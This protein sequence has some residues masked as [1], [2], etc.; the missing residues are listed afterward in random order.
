MTTTR[1]LRGPVRL[2]PAR[3]DGRGRGRGRL[4][5]DGPV[6]RPPDPRRRRRRR[7]R[8]RPAAGAARGAA[9]GARGGGDPGA[10]RLGLWVAERYC[11]TPSRGLAL[12]LPPGSGYRRASAKP[13]RPLTERSAGSPTRGGPR[14]RPGR[15]PAARLPPAGGSRALAAEGELPGPADPRAGRRR[16][17][18]PR[19]A[20]RARPDR[21]SGPR[22]PAGA[23]DRDRRRRLAAPP[24]LSPRQAAC[25]DE[26]IAALDG[27][28]PRERLLHGVTGSGQDRGLP[29]GD[30]G[31]ARARPDRDPARPRDRADA[32]DRR[33]GRR[34]ARRSGGGAPL[35]ALGGRALR[36]V[37]PAPLG[38]RAGLRRTALGG[39]RTARRPRAH[40]RRRGA[41]LLLQA[42]GRSR[43]TT[44]AP[45]PAAAPPTPER[46]TWPA[47][48]PRG[49]RAGPSSS[50][51]SSPSGSTAGRC[52]RSRSSTCARFPGGA[53]PLHPRT[54]EALATLGEGGRG[55]EGDRDAEPPRLL[56]AP[57]LRLLRRGGH[58][59]ELR[60]LAR[61]PPRPRRSS[62]ATTAA[63]PSRCRR[64]AGSAAR[65]RSPATAPGPSGSSS[66][67]ASSSRRRRVFRLDADT[68]SVAGRPRERARPSSSGPTAASSSA[69]RWS[70]RATTSPTSPSAC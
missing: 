61:P 58:L 66:S 4:A 30:R 16:L 65:S 29:G 15:R 63:T 11:S 24:R 2:P 19:P 27:T 10:R 44:P 23:A 46:S 34:P 40:R 38:R 49:R 18:R 5:A 52:R 9:R 35:G 45:S 20:R 39:L 12:V 55:L 31:D 48:R 54:R 21:A 28:A 42:G 64:R 37:A 51:S 25:A 59:P 56:A 57:E 69:P 7:R 70:P 32:A 1:A 22:G 47:A 26:L 60:R 14:S 62:A 53:G 17:G 41:R 33:P 36:R 6:R 50:A 43:A 8:E 3:A 67:S 68:A 13:K